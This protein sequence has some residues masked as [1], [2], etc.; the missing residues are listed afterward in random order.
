MSEIPAGELRLRVQHPLRPELHLEPGDAVEAEGEE[1]E[2]GEQDQDLDWPQQQLL[3]DP[4]EQSGDDTE[5]GVVSSPL[6]SPLLLLSVPGAHQA[7]AAA[8]TV[9]LHSPLVQSQQRYEPGHLK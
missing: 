8:V 3:R 6:G 9:V 2:A 5:L 1:A 7:A 4:A